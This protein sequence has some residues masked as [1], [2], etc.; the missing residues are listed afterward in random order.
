MSPKA[1]VDPLP[2]IN[3]P[4]PTADLAINPIPSAELVSNPIATTELISNAIPTTE[5]IN[6]PLSSTN[7]DLLLIAKAAE[8]KDA[9]QPF[10]S[11]ISLHQI[12][13]IIQTQMNV[14]ALVQPTAVDNDQSYN[15]KQG[16]R[17][18][19]IAYSEFYSL[20]KRFLTMEI[21]PVGKAL[22]KA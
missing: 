18:K 15:S 11:N 20:K 16:K 22:N 7:L 8:L 1:K 6:N 2:V 19:P 3:N 17:A 21:D 14:N 4:V 13:P 5:L 12:Q 9:S 10:A